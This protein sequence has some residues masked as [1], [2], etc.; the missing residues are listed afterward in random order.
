M[1]EHVTIQMDEEAL[2]RAREAAEAE[3]ITT[4]L[5]LEK[6][7]AAYLPVSVSRDRQKQLLSKIFGLGSTAEPTDIAKD[8][9]KLVGEAVWQE[10]L[11][12]TKQE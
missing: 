8:K 9:D 6:L 4:E 5:Y 12:G 7:I 11:R 2:A 10:Y 1:T 3:G